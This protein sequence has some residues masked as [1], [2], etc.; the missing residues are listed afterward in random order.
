MTSTAVALPATRWTPRLGAAL[1]GLVTLFML[2]D[3]V[4]HLAAP[5]PV[6]DAFRRLEFPT[7]LALPLGVVELLCIAAYVWPRTA[8]LGAILLTGYLG[9]AAAV[10]LR[11]G[12]PAFETLFPVIVGVLAWGALYLRDR[13]VRALLPLRG[14]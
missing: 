5:A 6:V 1:T 13:R 3:A 9:G 2:M 11:V 7:A 12:D 8:V 4:T 10:N 14:R